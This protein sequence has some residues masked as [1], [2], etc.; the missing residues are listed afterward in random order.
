MK[1]NVTDGSSSFLSTYAPNNLFPVTAYTGQTYIMF[2]PGEPLDINSPIGFS[3]H[4]GFTY[5]VYC[6]SRYFV[7]SFDIETNRLSYTSTIPLDVNVTRDGT[8]THFTLMSYWSSAP[9]NASYGSITGSVGL[10]GSGADLLVSKT[11]L[12]AGEPF[13]FFSVGFTLPHRFGY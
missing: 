5:I 10:P 12:S 1:L 4:Y 7:R 8:I 3:A 13:R 6:E 2:L 9:N 11:T